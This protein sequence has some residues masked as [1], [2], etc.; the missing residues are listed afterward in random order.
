MLLSV[1][2]KSCII[3]NQI[4]ILIFPETYSMRIGLFL[5]NHGRLF[6][7]LS[8]IRNTY[9]IRLSRV[10]RLFSITGDCAKSLAHISRRVLVT[11]AIR[12]RRI[13][14]HS[15]TTRDNCGVIRAFRLKCERT[16]AIKSASETSAWPFYRAAFQS[17]K[18]RIRARVQPLVVCAGKRA[19]F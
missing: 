8:I 2:F 15:G 6:R 16:S 5:H 11:C 12:G 3:S 7:R 9:N 1:L 14:L 4:F 17:E 18:R 19:P 13:R 10:I